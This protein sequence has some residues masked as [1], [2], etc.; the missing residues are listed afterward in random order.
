MLC[1]QLATQRA[2]SE[3]IKAIIIIFTKRHVHPIFENWVR[4]RD[5]VYLKKEIRI[6]DS[7]PF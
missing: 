2:C 4:L 5:M 1:Q 7:Q 6:A 3:Y